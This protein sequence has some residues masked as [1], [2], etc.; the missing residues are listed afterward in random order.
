MRSPFLKTGV[1][2]VVL[3]GLGAYIHF[4]DSKKPGPDEKKKEKVFTLDKAKV[5]GLTLQPAGGEKLRLAKD[6]AGWQIVEPKP[7]AADGTEADAIVS[8]VEGLELSEVVAESAAKLDEFGLAAPK[9]T[10]TLNVQGSPTPLVLLLGDKTPDGSSAYAKTGDKPRVFTIGSF[11]TAN[12]DKKPFDLRDR[13]LLK[14]KRDAV[15]TLDVTGPDGSY[16]LARND[17]GEWA[18]TKPVKTR[19]GKWSVDGLLGALET[20][21]MESIAAEEPKD[22]K[23]FGL[24]KPGRTVVLG[25]AD[26]KTKTL[27]IG[28]TAGDKKWHA[29]EASGSLVAVIPNAI[30]EDLGKGMKELRAKRVLDIA[31][32]E[33]EGFDVELEGAKKTYA[34]TKTKEG[35]AE[36]ETWKRTAPDAKDLDKNKVQDALF[37][38]GGTEVAEFIDAPK[39]LE[40]YGLDKPQA[41]VTIRFEGGKPWQWF[42]IGQK[43]GSYFARRIDDDAVLRLDSPKTEALIKGFKEL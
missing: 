39:G 19:A 11:V 31:T 28:S 16:S 38:V 35:E 42:E 37:N 5:E 25:L 1:A 23:P 43:D 4:V 27:Q 20:L 2:L 22:L 12:F 36:N 7:A 26:G 6:K 14:V 8:A 13:D 15:K 40:T 17:K 18:F 10:V 34:R 41:K 21:R 24:D 32:Y 9:N 30:E 33:V 29:R 3:L